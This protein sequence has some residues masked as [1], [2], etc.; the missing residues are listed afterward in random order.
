M[1]RKDG[2]TYLNEL[3]DVKESYLIQLGEYA[4]ENGYSDEPIFAW[5]V[6]VLMNKCD[7]IL[8]KTKSKDWAI[9]HKYGIRVPNDVIEAKKID[10]DNENTIWWYVIVLEMKNMIP[11]FEVYGGDKM[12]LVGY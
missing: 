3:K 1:Q 5:W 6:N 4:I 10:T 9:T 12:D 7:R 8:S 11:A 2:N